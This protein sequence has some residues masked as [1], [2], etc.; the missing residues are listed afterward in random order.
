M[1]R[2]VQSLFVVALLTLTLAACLHGHHRGPCGQRGPDCEMRKGCDKAPCEVRND[3]R[4]RCKD[5]PCAVPAE[6][7]AAAAAK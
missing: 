2:I 3:C 4:Q 5:A 6:K 1:K 7:N